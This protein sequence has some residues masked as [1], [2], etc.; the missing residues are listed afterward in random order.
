MKINAKAAIIAGITGVVIVNNIV[1]K[2]SMKNSAKAIEELSVASELDDLEIMKKVEE[3]SISDEEKEEAIKIL[4]KEIEHLENAIK[5][6]RK[7][8]VLDG[9]SRVKLAQLTGK[10]RA[11]IMKLELT[12]EKLT[13]FH[14]LNLEPNIA[15]QIE[16]EITLEKL[17]QQKTM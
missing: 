10:V 13:P 15:K 5:A 17:T 12:L 14:N 6:S 11:L 7:A 9:E 4:K 8:K 16:I 2:I 3:G 1:T